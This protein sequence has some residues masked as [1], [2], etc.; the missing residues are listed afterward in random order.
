MLPSGN[1]LKVVYE[2]LH[3][4][5]IS[6]SKGNY[7]LARWLSSSGCLPPKSSDLSLI[8]R[9]HVKEEDKIDST[10]LSSSGHMCPYMRAG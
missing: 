9:I 4:L 8:S 6:H 10:K 1:H 5:G 3:L 7:G 2:K